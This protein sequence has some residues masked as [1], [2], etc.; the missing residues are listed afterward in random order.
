MI[1]FAHLNCCGTLSFFQPSAMV[2]AEQQEGD[3]N[4]GCSSG[5]GGSWVVGAV[6]IG[7]LARTSFGGGARPCSGSRETLWRCWRILQ[8]CGGRRLVRRKRRSL[9]GMVILGDP[10]EW[11]VIGMMEMDCWAAML[12]V[13]LEF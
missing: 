1:V 7:H 5:V 2:R 11:W 8:Y 13:P 12:G 3:R 10:R 4:A 6:K 9:S